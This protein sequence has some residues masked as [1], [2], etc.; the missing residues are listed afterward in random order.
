M[1][2]LNRASAINALTHDMVTAFTR[3][4]DEWERDSA[5]GSVILAGS[6]QRGLCA[7][8][9]L[10][11]IYHSARADGA[12]A[13]RFWFDEYRLNARIGRYTKP[14]VAIMD[15]IVMGGGVGISAHAST[16]V[17]TESTKVALPQV[18]IGLIPDAGA[19][20]LMSR[21]PGLLGLHAALTGVTFS[22][23]DAIAVGLADHFVP[24]RRLIA[25]IDMVKAEGATAAVAAHATDPPASLLA[26]QRSWID[27]CYGGNTI[28]DIVRTLRRNG[29]HPATEAANLIGTRSPIALSVTLVALRRP[30]ADDSLEDALRMEYRAVCAASRSHDLVEGIRAHLIDRDRH[31]RWSPV[32][33]DTVSDNDIAHYFAPVDEELTFT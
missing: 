20:Y 7:G 23:A 26:A 15:G 18:G 25:F 10:V 31:P 21:A 8:G 14:F 27:D 33:I 13:R 17:V 2:T 12:E 5:V 32:S 24:R 19:T 28:V 11:P 16:R 29:A 3:A 30:A 22:G 6:G 4:I 9:D 1:L